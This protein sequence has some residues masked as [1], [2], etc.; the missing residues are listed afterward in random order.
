MHA[1][2]VYDF[3]STASGLSSQELKT[4]LEGVAKKWVFQLEQGDSGYRH[5]QGRMSLIKKRR[6]CELMKLLEPRCPQ[7][8]EP[9]HDT[10]WSYVM[11]KDTRIDGPW[12]DEDVE[13]YIPRQYRG[14]MDRL[15]PYQ[16]VIMDSADVFDTRSINLIYC[17][18]GGVGKTTVAMLC[19]LF[20]NG[21]TLPPINDQKELVQSCCDICVA[22]NT[23]NPSPIFIDLPRAMKKDTLHGIYSGIELIKNGDLYDLRYKYRE[24]LIDS[25]QIWVFSNM[26]PDLTMLSLDRW[27]VWVINEHKELEK[28]VF[29][30][31]IIG[32]D[33][34]VDSS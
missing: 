7:Y 15:Y 28:Y 11:K 3:R 20:K 30:P 9:S 29:T 31:F 6:K 13:V 8:L 33:Y 12:T 1:C 19:R 4:M 23:R 18:V 17:P 25:P 2:A 26:E 5:F 32:D 22:R 34:S 10:S 16:K 14:L 27:K 21:I 24:Y